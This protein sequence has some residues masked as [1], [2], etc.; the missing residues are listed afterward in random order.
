MTN[1]QSP[2]TAPIYMEDSGVKISESG[3]YISWLNDMESSQ[4]ENQAKTP[5]TREIKPKENVNI[6][7]CRRHWK[8]W[9]EG[10]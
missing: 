4:M 7:M 2:G 8:L 6:Q 10:W 1:P 9:Q 3:I 5:I